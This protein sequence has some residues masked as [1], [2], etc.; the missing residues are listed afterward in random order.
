MVEKIILDT[1]PG[2]DDAMALLFA[3]A[4]P[5]IE[6]IGITTV[7]GN[8]TVENSTRNAQFLKDKFQFTCDIAKGAE[9]PL[10]REPVGPSS[11]VH[12]E[13][14]FG[15]V[16]VSCVDMT[17]LSDKP[18][19]RYI[20]D[21]LRENPD[22]ITLVAVG[23]L[24]NLALALEED[25]SITSLVKEVVVMGGAFGL[26][27]RR[28]NITPHAEA[29]IH[30]DPHAA[31][32]VFSASW[33]ISVIGLDVTESSVFDD[34]YFRSLKEEAGQ[35]GELI[36][37][38]SRFYLKF[39]SSL[40]GFNGCH[41]H[42]PSAIACVVQPELFEFEVGAI[43]VTTE[44]EQ[45]GM[46]TLLKGESS[47]GKVIHKVAAKVNTDAL[48]TMYRDKTVAFGKKFENAK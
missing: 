15:D 1:D 20:I 26:N 9:A 38:V 2:I 42:D 40:I 19:Y 10:E 46:T 21:T 36:W 27:N 16:D 18:A 13:G 12:G 4:H 47:H 48:L 14:G 44:G 3:E 32:K 31:Q 17:G 33:P 23:P 45:Q 35:V 11:H 6:L 39:Y 22:E 29:N 7:F 30:D 25:E 43:E 8:A 34:C 24:T 37:D 41:V 5:D 28:G